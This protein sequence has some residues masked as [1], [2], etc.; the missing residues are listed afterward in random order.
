MQRLRKGRYCQE[1]LRVL[2][3]GS[4]NRSRW[5]KQEFFPTQ[6]SFLS[7]PFS[8]SS[9]IPFLSSSFPTPLHLLLLPPVEASFCC[10]LD[11]LSCVAALPTSHR[12]LPP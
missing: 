6:A 3:S 8:L 4:V 7:T 11:W 10:C 9:F 2:F 12:E 5:W 1:R